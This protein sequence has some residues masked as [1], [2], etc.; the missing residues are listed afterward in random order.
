MLVLRRIGHDRRRRAKVLIE[1]I[2]IVVVIVGRILVLVLFGMVV[3]GPRP[4]AFVVCTHAPVLCIFFLFSFFL[5][6]LLLV[7]C[8]EI[9]VVVV[10]VLVVLVV[11]I[12]LVL[13]RGLASPLRLERLDRA[14]AQI[15]GVRS[16]T[17]A[18]GNI[19]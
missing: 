1:I 15:I 2:V 9:L 11:H 14:R 17:A 3:K 13:Q 5:L 12:E 4:V 18:G 16:A 19:G 6:L 10:I 8:I 7:T